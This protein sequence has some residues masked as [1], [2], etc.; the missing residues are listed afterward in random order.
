MLV[1]WLFLFKVN[2]GLSARPAVRM[3]RPPER[4]LRGAWEGSRSVIES[5]NGK[6]G[7]EPKKSW[8]RPTGK[9]NNGKKDSSFL[10]PGG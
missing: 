4:I 8:D 2:T 7:E 6:D 1:G 3:C 10:K 5:P 9:R